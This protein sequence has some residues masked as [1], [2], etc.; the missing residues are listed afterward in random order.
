MKNKVV[1]VYFLFLLGLTICAQSC[2][3]EAQNTKNRLQEAEELYLQ[4]TS[5]NSSLVFFS[6]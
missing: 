5:S 2:Q 3:S 1:R 6:L 4:G